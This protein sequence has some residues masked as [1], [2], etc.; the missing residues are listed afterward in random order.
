VSHADEHL[1]RLLRELADP[2]AYPESD[3]EGVEPARRRVEVVQTHISVVFLT[4]RT[5]YKVKKPL[6]LWGFL[7]YGTLAARRRWCEEEVRLDRRLA[8]DLYRGVVPIARS[9]GRLVVGAAGAAEEHAVVMRRF[10]PED[11]LEARLAAGRA[12]EADVALVARLLARFHREHRLEEA[13]LRRA[14]PGL[15]AG[16]LAQNVRATLEFVP[17]LFPER[18]HASLA[19]RLA[20]ALRAERESL[21]RR[22][23][24]LAVDGHGDVRLEHVLVET[25]AT[26]IID[27]V[28]FT[29][30]LRHIDPLSDAAFLWMECVARGRRDLADAFLAAYAA[31][32]GPVDHGLLTLF[33]AYRAHVRAKVAA[34]T[35]AETEVP[36]AQRAAAADSARR[37][38]VLAWAL[39]GQGRG[40]AP[41][42]M[43]RGPS[44]SG[45]SVLA[46]EL[47]PWLDAVVVRSDEVR[48]EL[49]GLAP[50]AR[51]SGEAKEAL[52]ASSAS[53]RTYAEVLRRG[54]EAARA[55]RVAF[56][57]ATYLLARARRAVIDAASEAGVPWLVVDLETPP[58]EV[59][60]RLAERAARGDDAS[61]A[62]LGVYEQQLA[63]AEPLSAE[64]RV[65]T[66][67][68]RPG[69]DP[70]ILL[71]SLAEAALPP[72]DEGPS[73]KRAR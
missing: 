16:V 46:R 53:Q 23:A 65:R 64:E 55:G 50:L 27:A 26:S 38:L 20:R 33:A 8:P 69:D 36:A 47:A 72:P 39:A 25:G 29:T 30:R 7:D 5:A 4:A 44:G 49:F 37:H 43:L 10:R 14:V 34:T 41:I 21:R 66:L 42:V 22:A 68:A 70:S 56:L 15:F 51:P 73:G 31:A 28:E 2:A 35:S 9:G 63:E 19:A 1:A 11:T 40:P 18:L 45:K 6:A 59:R 52:Y 13:A 54:L 3:W 58:D 67:V 48:K 32:G 71:T 57:D 24:E 62:D 17:G 12:A 60:R 61:D